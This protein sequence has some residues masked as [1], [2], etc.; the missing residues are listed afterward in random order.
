M[1]SVARTF[2]RQAGP[3]GFTLVELLLVVSL[4]LL[5][6]SALVFNLSNLLRGHQLTEGTTR[7]ETLMR[8]ARAQAANSGRKVQLVFNS[9]STNTP[10]A[11]TGEVRATWEPD[12]L[13]QPGCYA[14]LVEAQWH[15]HE[16]ND[17]VQVESVTLLDASAACPAPGRS[18]DESEPEAEDSF[19]IKSLSPITFYPDGSSDSAEIIVSSRSL[20]EA[21]RMSVK[22]VGITGAISHQLLSASLEESFGYG[23]AAGDRTGK[24][25]RAPVYD[26][27]G[28]DAAADVDGL[29]VRPNSRPTSGYQRIESTAPRSTV[30][31]TNTVDLSE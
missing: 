1:N 26:Q 3:G 7:L 9:E 22:L 27:T 4:I 21:Q 14:D 8:F 24:V 10:A 25:R 31:E 11:T 13:G 16:L 2:R 30:G 19:S 5:F 23:E 20:E 17:L 29:A 15:V 28:R 12:P 6:S 18:E